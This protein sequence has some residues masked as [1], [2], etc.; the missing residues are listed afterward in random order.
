MPAPGPL[1]PVLPWFTVLH[2]ADARVPLPCSAHCLRQVGALE[3]A[4]E[5]FRDLQTLGLTPNVVTYCGL[6]SALGRERRRGLRF[7]A[8][9]AE[10]WD[11]L[12]GSGAQ[13]DAAAYRAGERCLA[14]GS[15]ARAARLSPRA[16]ERR[17]LRCRCLAALLLGLP[18]PAPRP[19]M[20]PHPGCV[21]PQAS[22]RWWMSAA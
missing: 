17:A 4:L 16:P 15:R 3:S 5:A 12:A 20:P 8:T 2:G 19:L 9:A 14:A 1:V 13:L 11:E 21:T 22:R 6:I 7:A 18:S 10:L